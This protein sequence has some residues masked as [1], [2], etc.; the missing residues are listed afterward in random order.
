MPP[1]AAPSRP[2]LP[3]P[4]TSSPG[5]A[6]AVDRIT[7]PCARPVQASLISAGTSRHWY[8]SRPA[9]KV[10]GR[11][12]AP[13]G[14]GASSEFHRRPGSIAVNGPGLLA[15]PSAKEIVIMVSIADKAVLVTGGNRGIG[16]ALVE[17]ALSRGARRVYAGTRQP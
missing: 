3:P 1:G 4:S 6:V 15:L 12:R 10:I 9:A 11:R 7:A 5:S 13:G 14:L 2:G 16:R 8:R 17:E